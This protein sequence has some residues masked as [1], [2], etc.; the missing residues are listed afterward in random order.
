MSCIQKNTNNM[1]YN[2]MLLKC[3]LRLAIVL[4]VT[5]DSYEPE[6]SLIW[7]VY[8][9]DSIMDCKS[10]LTV[11]NKNDQAIFNKRIETLA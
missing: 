6:P 10:S 3:F 5:Q 1:Y 2:L 9:R 4:V 11:T 7:I 8:H